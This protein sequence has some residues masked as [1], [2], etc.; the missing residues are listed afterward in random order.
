V[1]FDDRLQ[2]L[3]AHFRFAHK[4]TE[5]MP[6][7]P[8]RLRDPASATRARTLVAELRALLK[9]IEGPA[10]AAN[11][12]AAGSLDTDYLKPMHE[13]VEIHARA[14][15]LR[16]PEEWWPGTQREILAAIH[17]GDDAA[18]Q[19]ILRPA[20]E[21]ARRE[22]AQVRQALPDFP[23]IATYVEW[24]N[25]RASLDAKGWR[26]LLETQQAA[27]AERVRDYGTRVETMTMIGALR[28]PPLEWGIGRWQVSNRLLA[29][30]LPSPQPQFWGDW[31]AGVHRQ[32]GLEAVAFAA[33]RKQ[34]G[35][36]GEYVELPVSVP[37]PGQRDRL[38]LLLFLS[39]TNKD[40]FSNTMIP[41]RWAGYRFI[42]VLRGDEVWW[43]Q[44]LGTVPAQG[45]WYMVRLPRLA[46]QLSTLEL[47]LRVEDR[48]VSFNNY[49]MSYLGPVRLM[50]LPE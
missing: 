42:Q 6:P 8:P 17:A 28:S 40:L 34:P 23:R 35:E 19:R 13:A 30:V 29:T 44:D 22:V 36:I 25:S 9:A 43:E 31:L 32:D 1:Q 18:A 15:E 46:E 39:S 14:I 3:F 47:R 26:A 48:R 49:T 7:C 10:R 37:L 20:G 11:L 38:A 41:Y 24:W 27:L 21:R 5:G 45:E 4:A 33:Y 12:L 16:L 50:E 2:Q